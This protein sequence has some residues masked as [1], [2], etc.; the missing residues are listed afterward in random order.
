MSLQSSMSIRTIRKIMTVCIVLSAG[1]VFAADAIKAGGSKPEMDIAKVVIVVGKDAEA[2]EV[3][4]AE[5]LAKYV[6]KM[7]GIKLPI[8]KDNE[9]VT[10]ENLIFIGTLKSNDRIQEIVR[11][12]EIKTDKLDKD[13]DGFIIKTIGNKM[14]LIGSNPRSALYGVYA[15]L[16]RLGCLWPAPG[17]DFVPALKNLCVHDLDVAENADL[18]FRMTYTGGRDCNEEALVFMDWVAKNRSNWLYPDCADYF[19]TALHLT[20][21]KK[22]APEIKKRGFEVVFGSDAAVTYFLPWSKYGKEHPECFALFKGKRID[23]QVCVS[24]PDVIRLEAENIINFIKENPEVGAIDL[25]PGDNPKWCECE[26]CMEMDKPIIPVGKEYRV[27][28]N[29]YI[30]FQNEVL[31]RISQVFPNV[32]IVHQCYSGYRTPPRIILKKLNKNLC[33]VYGSANERCVIHPLWDNKDCGGNQQHCANIEGWTKWYGDNKRVFVFN[34]S[35][36]GDFYAPMPF[37]TLNVLAKDFPHFRDMSGV[38]IWHGVKVYRLNNYVS[39]RLAWNANASLDE[40]L[41]DYCDKYYGKAGKY[42]RNYFMK[43][44][45]IAPL[46][47]HLSYCGTRN[48]ISDWLNENDVRE[49]EDYLAMAHKVPESREITGRIK[50]LEDNFNYVKLVWQ[51]TVKKDMALKYRKDGDMDQAQKKKAEAIEICEKIRELSLKPEFMVDQILSGM[52]ASL[53]SPY[54]GFRESEHQ[55]DEHTVLLAHFNTTIDADYA[56]GTKEHMGI[57]VLTQNQGGKFGEGLMVAKDGRI[58]FKADQGKISLSEG[59]VEFWIKPNWDGVSSR[60]IFSITAVNESNQKDFEE[61]VLCAIG[62]QIYF[63]KIRSPTGNWKKD[64]WHHIAVSWKGKEWH[65][66]VD[67]KETVF[68]LADSSLVGTI[69]EFNLFDCDSVLDELRILDVQL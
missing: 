56:K 66:Y 40:I 50:E 7:S 23:S 1:G 35:S 42:I 60:K 12:G 19:V 4:A 44:E 59:T 54:K 9:A 31:N 67:G 25:C 53:A 34:S 63:G 47:G 33:A 48:K 39:M 57:A 15:F 49:F 3:F 13:R 29:S 38:V 65:L 6:E 41:T 22:N 5:E 27:T 11:K 18:D 32:K 43:W 46:M 17:E 55:P 58:G 8:A 20:D 30:N 61:V 26:K 62:G 21:I 10:N 16:E 45:K 69:K 14:F 28:S 36:G 2:P 37:P 24:N 64:E 68:T 52:A 51:A